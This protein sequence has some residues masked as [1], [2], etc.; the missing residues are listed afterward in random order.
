MALGIDEG[1]QIGVVLRDA[2]VWWVERDFAP[3]RA[4]LLQRLKQTV[5]KPRV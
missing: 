3:D 1:P 4:S 2:E 5:T